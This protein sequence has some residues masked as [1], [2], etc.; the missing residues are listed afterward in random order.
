[1]MMASNLRTMP[2]W[3][4]HFETE[5]AFRTGFYENEMPADQVEDGLRLSEHLSEPLV[6]P[7]R[8]ERPTT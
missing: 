4:K 1:M 5:R 2:A 7:F 6:E 3:E 8:P